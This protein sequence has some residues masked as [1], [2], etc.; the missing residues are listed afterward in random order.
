MKKT[1]LLLL[2][3]PLLMGAGCASKNTEGDQKPVADMTVSNFEE[4]LAAGNPAMESHPRQCMHEGVTYTENIDKDVSDKK[5]I[6]VEDLDV[7]FS[8]YEN[9]AIGYTINIPDNWYWQHFMKHQIS[10]AGGNELIDDYLIVDKNA[11]LGLGSEFLGQIVVEKSTMSLANLAK[12]KTSYN[13]KDITVAGM[14]ATRFELETEDSK[15]IEYHL[16]KDGQTFRLM[17]VS[18][19]LPANEK[20]FELMVKSFSFVE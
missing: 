19:D 11:L 2:I 12:D 13:K 4:C 3:V 6:V 16:D 15:M 1:F 9:K 5:N 14:P 18:S 17:Y 7:T 20:I 8:P 10:A